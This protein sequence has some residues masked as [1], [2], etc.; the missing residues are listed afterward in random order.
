[1]CPGVLNFLHEWKLVNNGRTILLLMFWGMF[2]IS[3]KSFLFQN[4]VV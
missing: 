4:I 1:M 2:F 3:D